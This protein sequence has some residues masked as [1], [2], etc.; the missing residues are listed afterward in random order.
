MY[1]HSVDED[2]LGDQLEGGDLLEDLVVGG[3][4]N[5]DGVVGLV[6]HLTCS[7]SQHQNQVRTHAGE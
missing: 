4:V 3:L 1:L 7:S 5:N 2:R 6:L